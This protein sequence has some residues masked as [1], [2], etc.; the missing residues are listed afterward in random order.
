MECVV[1]DAHARATAESPGRLV[2]R[3]ILDVATRVLLCAAVGAGVRPSRFGFAQGLRREEPGA[4]V[5]LVLCLPAIQLL[6]CFFMVL[7]QRFF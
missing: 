3:R 5:A 6:G 4:V 7:I 2:C 1:Q